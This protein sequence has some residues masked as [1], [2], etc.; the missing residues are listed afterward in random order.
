MWVLVLDVHSQAPHPH[1]SLIWCTSIACAGM[2][3]LVWSLA[4]PHEVLRQPHGRP[5][6]PAGPPQL[7]LQVLNEVI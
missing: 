7:L 4:V 3:Q 6:P 5:L 1:H 2:A